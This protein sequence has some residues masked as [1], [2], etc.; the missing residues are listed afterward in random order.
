MSQ[1]AT[2]ESIPPE[3]SDN[4]LP[5]VPTGR[6]P[7]PSC[8]FQ[9]I[10]A[11]DGSIDMYSVFC[12][13]FRLTR[14]PTCLIISAPISRSISSDVRLYDLSSL[15]ALILNVSSGLMCCFAIS[16]AVSF[17]ESMSFGIEYPSP[18]HFIP[19][20]FFSLFIMLIVCWLSVSSR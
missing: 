18:I 12:G 4:T 13:F 9:I 3:K 2:G 17:S 11:S 1:L 15:V 10:I 5:L 7:G 19:N 20:T 6:P 16:T 14:A 8:L